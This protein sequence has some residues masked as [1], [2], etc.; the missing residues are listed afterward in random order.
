MF[1]S[2]SLRLPVKDQVIHTR[3][4]SS[5][6]T[7]PQAHASAKPADE[8]KYVLIWLLAD[9]LHTGMVFPYDWLLESGFVP[10]EN[11]GHPLYV[12]MSWGNRDAYVEKRWLSPWKAARALFTP[13]P[14]VMEIIPITWDVVDVVP[15][16][17]VYRKLL[18]RDQGPK[19]AAF[20]NKC[21]RWD[22]NDHPIS[23]GPS[24]WGGGLLLE[25]RYHYF[26]PRIC[27]VWTVQ[28]IE[29]TGGKMNPWFGITA[30]GVIR[31]AVKSPNDYEK[32]WNGPEE[33][34][35]SGEAEDS[36]S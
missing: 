33:E 32:V 18:E 11:F 7:H 9:T 2:C 14:A 10:P 26:F 21:S 13:S 12:S 35:D 6:T 17:R 36:G 20:L 4:S 8:E 28:A 15:H 1:S 29:A 19:L 25:S 31:Q 27:N 24:S 30:N 5:A 16:Q 22:E 23:I 3:V 34:A